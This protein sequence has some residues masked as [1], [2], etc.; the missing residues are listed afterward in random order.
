MRVEGSEVGV[1]VDDYPN[2]HV[3][4][5]PSSLRARS[6]GPMRRALKEGPAPSGTLNAAQGGVRLGS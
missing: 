4:V 3:R 6:T 5:T 1:G 2:H